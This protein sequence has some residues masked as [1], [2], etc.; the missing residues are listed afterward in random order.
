MKLF[1][2]EEIIAY[3]MLVVLLGAIVLAC[4]MSPI[5]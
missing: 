5:D 4:H 1:E 2:E 3:W